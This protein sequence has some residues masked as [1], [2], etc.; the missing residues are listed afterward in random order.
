[1]VLLLVFLL[2][3]CLLAWFIDS[4]WFID[5]ICQHAESINT[6]QPPV[7]QYGIILPYDELA[8]NFI[9][10][11][12]AVYARTTHTHTQSDLSEYYVWKKHVCW[13]KMEKSK[14]SWLGRRSCQTHVSLSL[15]FFLKF[16]RAVRR[17]VSS[18][19]S[20]WE[21]HEHIRIEKFGTEFCFSFLKFQTKY[22]NFQSRTLIRIK[23]DVNKNDSEGT[24]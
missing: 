9:H 14:Q 1:M 22:F 4:L 19:S 24:E 20:P 16:Y 15:F 13:I 18:S 23:I 12:L 11:W 3:A 10:K 2:F 17:T 6:S 7:L 8:F 21:V 5:F